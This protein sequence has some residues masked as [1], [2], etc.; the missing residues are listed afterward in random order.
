MTRAYS[1][2]V[3]L[4]ALAMAAAGVAPA[5]GSTASPS[6]PG[7]QTKV[8][9]AATG[10]APALQASGAAL[11]GQYIV[12]YAD[13]A[14]PTRADA[15]AVGV[16]P[17]F[18]YTSGVHGYSATLTPAQLDQVRRD[19]AVAYV[20]QDAQVHVA[21]AQPDPP[22][23]LDRIDQDSLPLDATYVSSGDGSGVTAYVVDTG[24][25]ATHSQ[26][27]GRVEEGFT[28]VHDGQGSADCN[29]HGTHVAATIGGTDVGVAKAVTLVPVRV[30]GCDGT[31]SWSG[32]L[33]GL[34]WVSQGHGP[35]SVANL[36]IGGGHS[37][38]VDDAIA[39]TVAAGVTVVVAAGNEGRDACAYS[40][41]SAA[42]AITVGAT[43]AEDGAAGYSNYGTCLDLYAP[44]T[45]IRSAWN[46]SDTA[47]AVL[48][49]TSMATP[50]VT[51]V[52]ALQ[53]QAH[54]DETPAQIRDRI[55]AEA[56]PGLL[57]WLMPGD[58][59]LLLRTPR[60]PGT[61]RLAPAVTGVDLSA[62][63]AD[64]TATVHAADEDGGSGLA[65]LSFAW[66]QRADSVPDAVVDQTGSVVGSHL[67]DGVWYLHVRAVDAAENWSAPV[68]AGPVT[69]DQ[70]APVVSAVQVA[71]TGL[72]AT[73]T[74]RASDAPSGVA[75]YSITW[76]HRG[77]GSTP[78]S[79]GRTATTNRYRLPAGRWFVHVR[80][81][82]RLGNATAVTTRGPYVTPGRCVVPGVRGLGIAQAR[83][84]LLYA[85]CGYAG[86]TFTAT[87]A[88]AHASVLRASRGSGAVLAY[89]TPVRLYARR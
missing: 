87:T 2:A 4:V 22:W 33:A 12:V 60:Q 11:P 24:I 34:S 45:G 6:R 48:S 58:P 30:L 7:P 74:V 5:A 77:A 38:S 43:D 41:A 16:S 47:M 53:V 3:A 29:G 51:G 52:A 54:P 21:A 64:A 73:V 13:G 55:V 32:L 63:G 19:P 86:T 49:G 89:G 31:G 71:V 9:P 78:A 27:A 81:L 76:D 8:S 46:T 28:A 66:T 25:R 1:A 26:L 44:G 84:A 15:A 20:E 68:H 69:I 18:V 36:S 10:L 61:D 50:H 57:A 80:V 75:G 37:Q 56:T 83:T 35:R 42:E 70:N 85:G 17:L 82:D 39:A 67:G 23:G 59:D 14:R 65:G 40:P 72:Y 62:S 79:V 88:V